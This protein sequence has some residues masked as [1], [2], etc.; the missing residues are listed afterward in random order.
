[1]TRDVISPWWLRAQRG[2]LKLDTAEESPAATDPEAFAQQLRDAYYKQLTRLVDLC[3]AGDYDDLSAVAGRTP[4]Y[5]RRMIRERH[6]T[7]TASRELVAAL[8]L[9]LVGLREH[10]HDLE[11]VVNEVGEMSKDRR[12]RQGHAKPR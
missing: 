6:M 2:E 10:L 12:A 1:M 11:V 4:A 9:H 5:W 7:E 3:F 8:K